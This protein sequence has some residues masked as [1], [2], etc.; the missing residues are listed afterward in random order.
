MQYARDGYELTWEG[1]MLQDRLK[2]VPPHLFGWQ[3][4]PMVGRQDTII[5]TISKSVGKNIPSRVIE[6][7][8]DILGLKIYCTVLRSQELPIT[9]KSTQCHLDIPQKLR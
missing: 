2:K 3:L 1:A 5:M 4:S 9:K 7:S 8:K 6:P